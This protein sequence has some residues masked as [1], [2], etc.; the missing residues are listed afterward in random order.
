M[1]TMIPY[2]STMT[3]R[4]Y[5]SFADS[6]FRSFFGAEQSGSFRVDVQD[7]G[8]AYVLEA[9]LPG[10]AR[11]NIHVDLNEDTLTISVESNEN[12]EKKDEN[13]Y[14]MRERRTGCASRSFNVEGICRENISAAYENG[15]LTLTLPKMIEQPKP[16]HRRID[17]A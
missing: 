2:R 15:V 11:E 7:K 12:T 14:I 10:V 17:I 16:T 9:D 3:T 8:N 1:L 13:G 6:F 4:P 5:D